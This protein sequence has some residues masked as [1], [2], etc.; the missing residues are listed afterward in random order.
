MDLLSV[1][2]SP[3]TWFLLVV[4][5]LIWLYKQAYQDLDY[6]VKQ[7]IDGPKPTPL[8]GNLWGVWKRKIVDYDF[9]LVRKYG[10][11]YGIFDGNTP[12]LITM[13]TDIIRSV[14]VKD[15]DHFV[16]R[17]SFG[18]SSKYFRKM[19]TLIRDQ[20]WKDVRSALTPTFTTGKIKRM[21]P[22]ILKCTDDLSEKIVSAAKK[23]GTITPKKIFSSFTMEVIN[24]CAF[25]LTI[26]NLDK[27]DSEFMINAKAVNNPDVAK[28]P[29]ILIPFAFGD[30][31]KRFANV[32]D[33]KEIRYFFK[34]LEDV[35]KDRVGSSQKY[36][37][38][39]E[40]TTEAILETKREV[41]GEKVPVYTKEEVE[42]FVIAQAVLFLL[43]GFDTTALT[44]TNASYV[45]ATNPEIQDTLYQKVMD[46]IEEHGKVCHEMILDFPY[47]DQFIHEVLRMYSPVPRLERQCNQDLTLNGIHIKKGM[48]VSIPVY[49]LHFSE[50]YY[51]RP[52][53]FD[54]TRWAP[55]NKHK[56]N[57]Y[58]YTPFGLGPR[59]CVGMR[60]AMEELKLALCSIV[61]R[62]EFSRSKDTPDALEHENGFA[63]IVQVEEFTVNVQ[64]R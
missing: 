23:S 20:D 51:D 42:E 14:Y 59:N 21:S 13:D 12:N 22:L 63:G 64:A 31:L 41:N 29:M 25:G 2:C 48:I 19:L 11:T 57:P 9:G 50:E 52:E 4:T 1:V 55:E 30:L 18:V 6:F 32:F 47:I 58:A 56:L 54:P 40:T 7:G 26:D 16:N 60:F 15:F 61:S 43:A 27:E 33:S 46:K 34:I 49:P 8:V 10:K 17:R 28:S 38:V 62:F 5:F 45:L 35:L 37:D 3:T 53:T 44:L 24:K 39:I 36:N